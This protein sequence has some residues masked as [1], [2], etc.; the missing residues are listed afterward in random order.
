[1]NTIEDRLCLINKCI[2]TLIEFCD[3]QNETFKIE[4]Y[5][6]SNMHF[7]SSDGYRKR[8]GRL[9]LKLVGRLFSYPN[10]VLKILNQSMEYS[11]SEE[12]AEVCGIQSKCG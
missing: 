3:I 8:I 4:Q 2:C 1:M 5:S 10:N 6:I 12:R 9:S 7:L 11:G